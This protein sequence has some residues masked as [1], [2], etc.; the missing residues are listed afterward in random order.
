MTPDQL[1]Y[2][3][4]SS[5]VSTSTA[6][7]VDIASNSALAHGIHDITFILW[8][9]GWVIALTCGFYIGSYLYKK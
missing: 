2:A 8:F 7:L 1:I 5:Y 3:S 9:I 4:Q 6:Q